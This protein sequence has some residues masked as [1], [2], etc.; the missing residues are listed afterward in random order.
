MEYLSLYMDFIK[1]KL[2][3]LTEY[4]AAFWAQ[5][6]AKMMGWAAD[7]IIIYLMVWRFESVLSWSA[8]EVLLLYSLNATAYALA[9]FFMFNAFGRLSLHIQSG[10]FDEILTKPL[11]PFLYLCFKGFST[12]Y[13]G[14]LIS[15]ITAM[16]YSIV[17]LDIPMDFINIFYLIIIITGSSLIH[18]AVFMFS[19]IPVFWIIKADAL[20]SFRWALDEFIRYPISIYDRW[21]QI[22]LTFVFPMAFINFYPAQYFLRK[23]DF[24]GF[25]PIFVHLTPVIGIFLFTLAYLFFFIGVRN[26][27]S[28]GS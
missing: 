11:N 14:N 15:T 27:K 12:G 9:G 5:S 20:F 22:M 10:T 24:L 3:V 6:I 25:S 21:I 16:I 23:S 26:Y 17:K 7:L 28:T 2:R 8:Y 4:P 18:A 13:V 19:N 1:I